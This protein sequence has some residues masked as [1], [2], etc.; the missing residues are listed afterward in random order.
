LCSLAA[1]SLGG[2]A[3]PMKA[4]GPAAAPGPAV[5]AAALDKFDKLKGLFSTHWVQLSASEREAA[6][7]LYA[8]IGHHNFVGQI[9]WTTTSNIKND[10]RELVPPRAALSA[11]TALPTAAEAA[12]FRDFA[13]TLP[14]AM[15]AGKMADGSAWPTQRP[16]PI[17]QGD[18]LDDVLDIV[19]EVCQTPLFWIILVLAI[20]AGVYMSLPP[21]PAKIV[22]VMLAKDSA[23][24]LERNLPLWGRLV[25]Y[26]VIGI[27]GRSTDNSWG[28]V[29]RAL[30]GIPHHIQEVTEFEG[31]GP[32]L[33]PL[34]E[35]ALALFPDA[36]AGMLV[37]PDWR[38]DPRSLQGW[39]ATR[40][41][42]A[43]RRSGCP[44]FRFQVVTKEQPHGGNGLPADSGSLGGSS[45][46][47]FGVGGP[48]R[49]LDWVYANIEGVTVQRRAHQ[50]VRSLHAPHCPT[51]TMPIHM[52]I[53]C[54]SLPCLHSNAM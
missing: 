43:A 16:G 34:V 44:L 11:G 54:R 27:D 49:Q 2:A 28:A 6:A 8:V 37:E 24:S 29:S 48:A 9:R 41:S 53:V 51:F 46:S 10:I 4:N 47:R 52:P 7:T 30:Q 15:A 12:A 17:D 1:A 32:A 18:L 42:M 13:K 20:V 45:L 25:D 19:A 50:Q 38:P 5:D 23:A 31:Y 40:R 33:T 39:N 22:L 21:P 36:S 35:K 14:A 3:A 26:A